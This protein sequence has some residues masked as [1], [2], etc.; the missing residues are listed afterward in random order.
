MIGLLFKPFTSAEP[1]TI[2]ELF[3]VLAFIYC[4][5]SIIVA[6]VI[7]FAWRGVDD[8][9]LLRRYLTLVSVPFIWSTVVAVWGARKSASYLKL[10]FRRELRELIP[11]KQKAVPIVVSPAE[12]KSPRELGLWE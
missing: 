1:G 11:V 6:P 10:H 4:F 2:G 12:L 8:K 9:N 3:E 5:L 7:W